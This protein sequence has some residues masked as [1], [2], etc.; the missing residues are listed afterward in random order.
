[1]EQR[2]QRDCGVSVTW[3]RAFCEANTSAAEDLTTQ[4]V[5]DRVILHETQH[6]QCRYVDLLDSKHVG[7]VTYFVSHRW[8]ASFRDLVRLVDNYCSTLHSSRLEL[9]PDKTFLWI[10]LFAVNQ[11]SPAADLAAIKDV[12]ACSVQTLLCIDRDQQV[13]TRVWCVYEVWRTLQKPRYK[14]QSRNADL[15]TPLKQLQ[16]CQILQASMAMLPANEFQAGRFPE[17]KQPACMAHLLVL[18]PCHDG[19]CIRALN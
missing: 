8:Q 15:A 10:D 7:P 5:A 2:S 9:N 13:L 3:L 18:Q 1:M 19:C 14:R 16:V 12:I 11:H 17:S 4:Q 6:Q